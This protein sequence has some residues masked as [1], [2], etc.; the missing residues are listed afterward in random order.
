MKSPECATLEKFATFLRSTF[1]A[2]IREQTDWKET[3]PIPFS[4]TPFLDEK[5]LINPDIRRHESS[6]FAHEKFRRL[7]F[8]ICYPKWKSLRVFQGTIAQ[9]MC[10]HYLG[11]ARLEG[12]KVSL[13]IHLALNLSECQTGKFAPI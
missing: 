3:N 12:V 2:C 4:T 6:T 5:G 8:W 7:A 1:S 11:L 10:S 9:K 13:S